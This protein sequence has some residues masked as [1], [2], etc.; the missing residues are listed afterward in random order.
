MFQRN[1]VF[2]PKDAQ[3][4]LYLAK[5][6][7]FEE[8]EKYI[9]FFKQRAINQKKHIQNYFHNNN[10][11][12]IFVDSLSDKDLNINIG[13]IFFNTNDI[14]F[15]EK[16]LDHLIYLFFYNKSFSLIIKEK[17][18]IEN[19]TVCSGFLY[20]DRKE[21]VFFEKEDFKEYFEKNKKTD[22]NLTSRTFEYKKILEKLIF[23]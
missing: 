23:S 21:L 12:E 22:Q 8:N 7:N 19:R 20:L 4:Y 1:I 15:K 18:N 2:N 5:I 6:Y 16:L 14:N 17:T 11:L 9:E 3:S 13:E 10:I